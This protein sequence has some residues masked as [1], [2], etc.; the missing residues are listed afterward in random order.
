MGLR[1]IKDGEDND[2]LKEDDTAVNESDEDSDYLIRACLFA[3]NV[4][5][6]SQGLLE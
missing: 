4:Q 5:P 3:N 1:A 6:R 2:V